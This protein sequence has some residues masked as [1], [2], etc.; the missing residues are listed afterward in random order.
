MMKREGEWWYQ[1]RAIGDDG[2][3]FDVA[4]WQAQ[5]STAIFDAAWQMVLD[6]VTIKGGNPDELRLL[7][8]PVVVESIRR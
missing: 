7:R 4:F 8:S 1:A 6:S 5:G 2:R 3:S